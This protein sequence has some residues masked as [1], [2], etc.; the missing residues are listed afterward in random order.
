MSSVKNYINAPV[1]KQRSK[2]YAQLTRVLT[3]NMG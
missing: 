3:A 1:L 2:R